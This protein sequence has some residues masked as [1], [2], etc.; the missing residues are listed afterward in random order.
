M[1]PETA[2]DDGRLVQLQRE[3][4]QALEQRIKELRSLTKEAVCRREGQVF[5][6]SGDG[7]SLSPVP[8]GGDPSLASPAALPAPPEVLSPGAEAGTLVSLMDQTTALILVASADGQS[9]GMGSGFFVGPGLLLTNRHVVEN[10]DG[11]VVVLNKKV[12]HP[13]RATVKSATESSDPGGPDFALI[14][15]PEARALPTLSF[16]TTA[17]R[18]QAVIAAGFP[19]L[20]TETDEAFRALLN[21]DAHQIPEVSFTEGIVTA[22][23]NEGGTAI[24]LHSAAISPGNSGGPLI[25]LCG[26]VVGINTF[27]RAEETYRRMNYALGAQAATAFMAANGVTPR[28]VSTPCQPAAPAAPVAPAAS[29]PP[30]ASA[31]PGASAPPPASAT[32]ERASPGGK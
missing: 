21:G 26:R 8:G 3:S 25:D 15:V 29:A 12:G 11:T 27:V 14:D 13:L 23:Q 30:P 7:V 6:P 20:V 4:N 9:L 5:A 17:E 19:S 28:E 24:L 1:Y 32:P 16:S 18:M 22:R 2:L 31:P 10:S